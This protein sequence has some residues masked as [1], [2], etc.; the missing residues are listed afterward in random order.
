MD[1][2][3]S[4]R[5]RVEIWRLSNST[6]TAFQVQGTESYFKNLQCKQ[7]FCFKNIE[8]FYY[9]DQ[10]E[11]DEFSVKPIKVIICEDNDPQNKVKCMETTKKNQ[12][13]QNS[14]LQ[15][16]YSNFVTNLKNK[17]Q[18]F[19]SIG[20]TEFWNASTQFLQKI[21]MKYVKTYVQD[22]DALVLSNSL[23]VFNLN[24][25]IE[26]Q[27]KIQKNLKQLLKEQIQSIQIKTSEFC[28][29]YLNCFRRLQSEVYQ[30]V[31][32]G[33]QQIFNYTDIYFVVNK[34][35]E[36]EKLKTVILNDQQ[37]KLFEF[38]P[39]PQTD[40]QLIQK[41]NEQK[42]AS[43]KDKQISKTTDLLSPKNQGD[44]NQITS[45]AEEF[46]LQQQQQF[47]I[48]SIKNRSI[49]EKAKQAQEVLITSTTISK[50]QQKQQ[51]SSPITLNKMEKH[52]CF[53]DYSRNFIRSG[54]ATLKYYQQVFFEGK[55]ETSYDIDQ[56]ELKGS[57]IQL[58]QNRPK[59]FIDQIEQKNNQIFC[60]VT[61][62]LNIKYY[63]PMPPM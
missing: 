42:N 53:T 52:S 44:K 37:I 5:Y 62:Q 23:S 7:M 41:S 17:A 29:Y 2:K 47:N 9:V 21:D 57:G 61:S 58:F 25:E 46:S 28:C 56:N 3:V 32:F 36:L 12:I 38:L 24:E 60:T 31:N 43:N 19:Q 30:I 59:N 40:I 50:T 45:Q 10:F 4:L 18:P 55:Q 49:Y 13:L 22:D 54:Q 34:L 33:T 20:Q 15:I 8:D 63:P 27:E 6:R 14:S 1:L 11:N 48:L 39:R 51:Y 35:I 26:N 16:N